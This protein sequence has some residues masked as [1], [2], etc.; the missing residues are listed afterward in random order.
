MDLGLNKQIIKGNEALHCNNDVNEDLFP[1]Y[2]CEGTLT[3]YDDEQVKV[4]ILTFS[5]VLSSIFHGTSLKVLAILAIFMTFYYF[6]CF[7]AVN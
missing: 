5:L 4:R 6:M 2:L 7:E 3:L 1:D